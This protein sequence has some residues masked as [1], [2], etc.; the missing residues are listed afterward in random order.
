M[1]R[2]PQPHEIYKHFKGNLY[3]ILAVAEHSETAEQLVI[4]QAMY[5]EHKV[6]ARPLSDFTAKLD[7]EKYPGAAQTCR[8]ELQEEKEIEMN[9]MLLK[10]L[11][12]DTYRDRLEILNALKTEITDE[13]I[14]TMAIACDVEVPEGSL[15]ER[16]AGLKNCLATLEKYECNRLR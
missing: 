14:T 10:F 8:F 9:P 12:A 16:F 3:E 6:Y 5:G 7:P 4:Y 2:I 1:S 13:M 15:E 11:D